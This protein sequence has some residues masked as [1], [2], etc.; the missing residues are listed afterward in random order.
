MER[1]A[2]A[3]L[4]DDLDDPRRRVGAVQRRRRWTLHDL[5]ALDVFRIQ[6][7]QPT[8]A[9]ATGARR[10]PTA[11]STRAVRDARIDAHTVDEHE[12]IIRQGDGRRAANSNPRRGAGG[13]RA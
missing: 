3:A 9:L 6:I 11:V 1:A 8:D 13:T 2:L 7:V 5:D 10:P 4:G 12:R